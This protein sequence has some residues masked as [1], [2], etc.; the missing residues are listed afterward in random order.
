VLWLQ[1]K[2]RQHLLLIRLLH[3]P[4]LHHRLSHRPLHHHYR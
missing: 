4:L 1:L 3:H 2:R